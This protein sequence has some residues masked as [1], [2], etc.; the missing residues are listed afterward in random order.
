[1]IEK[2]QKEAQSYSK[3]ARRPRC[4]GRVAIRREKGLEIGLPPEGRDTSYSLKKG[5]GGMWMEQ[6]HQATF[7]RE[8]H[9]KG[10]GG[11]SSVGDRPLIGTQKGTQ[12]SNAIG[13][14]LK[15]VRGRRRKQSKKAGSCRRKLI[16]ATRT[17]RASE[18]VNY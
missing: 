14:S 11:K 18:E 1:M 12:I 16:L 17:E 9:R 6:H 13:R 3:G 4:A 2:D 5:G 7:G 10:G 8:R 15:L